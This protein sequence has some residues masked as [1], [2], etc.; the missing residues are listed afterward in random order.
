MQKAE[1]NRRLL[2]MSDINPDTFAES[3][4][5]FHEQLFSNRQEGSKVNVVQL[6]LAV[7]IKYPEFAEAAL[8]SIWAP[9]SSV[10]LKLKAMGYPPSPSHHFV[11]LSQVHETT[12]TSAETLEQE[13][14][15]S[16]PEQYKV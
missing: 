3:Y 2:F 16:L 7:K 6:L 9:V 14:N 8:C 13:Y 5:Y 10:V 1:Q 11:W 12:D 15:F 4:N